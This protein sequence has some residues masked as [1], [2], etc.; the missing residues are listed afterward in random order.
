MT[1]TTIWW[2]QIKNKKWYEMYCTVLYFIECGFPTFR[3]WRENKSPCEIWTFVRMAA[4]KPAYLARQTYDRY[5]YHHCLATHIINSTKGERGL[6]T[7]QNKTMGPIFTARF[8]RRP[9]VSSY[10]EQ[11]KQKRVGKQRNKKFY[12]RSWRKKVGSWLCFF[13]NYHH[14]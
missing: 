13:E 2:L 5:V 8:A 9:D 14:Y 10:H 7:A 6:A 4:Q 1:L 11:N 12:R 3:V